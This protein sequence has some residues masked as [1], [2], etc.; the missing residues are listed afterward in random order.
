MLCVSI[1]L[2]HDNYKYCLPVT[3]NFLVHA[4]VQSYSITKKKKQYTFK[5][6]FTSYF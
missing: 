3:A 6:P 1:N 5:I 2:E 4:A